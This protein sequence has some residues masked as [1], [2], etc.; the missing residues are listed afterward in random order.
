MFTIY[1][2]GDSAF[3]A[4]ILNALAMI[5]GTGDFKTL[6]GVGAL[7]GLLVMGFQCLTSGT[8]QFNLHQVLIGM[9][10]YMCFFGP[11]VT[12]QVEDAYT[13]EVRV[14]DNVPLGAA[15]AGTIISNIGYGVT[16]LFEQGYGTADR[17][18][19]HAFLEPL[20]VLTGVRSAAR[21]VSIIEAAGKAI[22][23]A[24]LAQ[25]IDNYLRECTMVKITLGQATP[26]A[27]YR[28]GTNE[29]FY[30]SSVYGTHLSTAGDVTCAEATAFIRQSL[31]ALGEPDAA[32]AL[33]RLLNIKE[34]GQTAQHLDKVDSALQMLDAAG[35]NGTQYLQLA[36]LQPLYDKAAAGFYKDMGDTASAVMVNQAI[37]QRN[38][39]WAAEGT[40]FVSTMRPLMAFF[41]GFIYAITPL[42]GFLLV[43]GAF[44]LNMLGKYFQVV[45]WIQ[46][47]MPVM[48]IINLYISM[49]ARNEFSALVTSPIS[50]YTLNSGS[51]ALQTWLGV[52]GMLTA[53][54]P[55]IA[56]FLVTGSTY[57][58][59][60]LA[61]RMGGADHVNE[62]IG[63]PDML[64]PGGFLERSSL[65][66][67]DPSRGTT[68]TG[69]PVPEVAVG[70]ALANREA[71][72]KQ[73]VNT[74]TEQFGKAL[75]QSIESGSNHGLVRSTANQIGASVKADGSD[76]FDTIANFARD[77]GILND[78]N[79]NQTNAIVGT[80]SSVIAANA[81]VKGSAGSNQ[82]SF[83]PTYSQDWL[84]DS[85]GDGFFHLTDKAKSLMNKWFGSDDGSQGAPAPQPAPAAP[86]GNTAPA[87]AKATKNP[88]NLPMENRDVRSIGMD[89]GV[90]VS[91]NATGAESST[92]NYGAGSSNNQGQRK[93]ISITDGMRASLAQSV[94]GGVTKSGNES[95]SM[96]S[97]ET[98]SSNLSR[99][100]ADLR[101]A[102]ETYARVQDENRS[103]S[104]V[105]K[106]SL[107][108]L[109]N[110]IASNKQLDD[111]LMEM[112]SIMSPA[113]RA[114]VNQLTDKYSN[115]NGRYLKSKDTAQRMAILETIGGTE[116]LGGQ[117]TVGDFIFET[118]GVSSPAFEH[119]SKPS[120]LVEPTQMSSADKESALNLHE[121]QGLPK[122]FGERFEA[123]GKETSPAQMGETVNAASE[124]FKNRAE[125][126]GEQRL[127]ELRH[128]AMGKAIDGLKQHDESLMQRVGDWGGD[129]YDKLFVDTQGLKDRAEANGLTE[130]QA[131][132]WSA[133]RHNH[134]A[135]LSP[136]LSKALHSEVQRGL[137]GEK[138]DPEL[139]K[140]VTSDIEWHTRQSASTGNFGNMVP[141]MQFNAAA[142]DIRSMGERA[143]SAAPGRDVMGEFGLG[144]MNSPTG[145]VRLGSNEQPYVQETDAKHRVNPPPEPGSF[146]P[147]GEGPVKGG[148]DD[149]QK[150]TNRVLIGKLEVEESH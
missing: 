79:A 68:M 57:A 37:E 4:Q 3:L 141:V 107:D 75:T 14:V 50:F 2:I 21:D 86:S 146:A 109:A 8:R 30:D 130:T 134:D 91:A 77:E 31:G 131:L 133:F 23:N 106:M 87:N 61:G 19:E 108:T 83:E 99:S 49:A 35:N 17:M 56:L 115:P 124:G 32:A 53:A 129:V 144:G 36:V 9:I 64:K 24:D 52:G 150:Q 103:V 139:V 15:A 54:T 119:A 38:Q 22:G 145:S 71:R 72:G 96:S 118:R 95:F 97:G 73:L 66:Q 69:A 51:Q 121:P 102:S 110:E 48:S 13:D 40:M 26:D 34:A 94:V 47:W 67:S 80:L 113:E 117:A 43:V 104:M 88:D 55:M 25:D 98:D 74:Q 136:A 76:N 12:V 70:D 116:R 16:A 29:L 114:Q 45:I 135:E 1:S 90:G 10:C 147:S 128:A 142:Y 120:S 89:A 41:E 18:T 6:V 27:I 112:K 105:Q 122:D 132:M 92:A 126:F 111:K 140:Q 5:C 58:F 125:Q 93:G 59:T 28:G 82:K 11:G 33:N 7:L 137:G 60:A 143:Q 84:S 44:G 85:D 138:A 149:A 127:S 20:K 39:Q 62:R 101:S 65:V 123:L 63:S 81:G 100:M 46:L 78:K 42:M 148:L